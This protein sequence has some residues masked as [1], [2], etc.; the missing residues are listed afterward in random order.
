[1]VWALV[2]HLRRQKEELFMKVGTF[3]LGDC[4]FEGH[5]GL[6]G[7]FEPV[8][9]R[10]ASVWFSDGVPIPI[11]PRLNARIIPE[12]LILQSCD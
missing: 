6:E 2:I 4:I 12:C 1:M 7:G 3:A 8:S 5:Y 11:G 10:I 9:S